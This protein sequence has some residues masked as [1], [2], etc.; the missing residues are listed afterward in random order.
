MQIPFFVIGCLLV[1]VVIAMFPHFMIYY[2]VV[3]ITIIA[4]GAG[5]MVCG[6]LN[7]GLK[8]T[9]VF[10]VVLPTALMAVFYAYVEFIARPFIS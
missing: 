4:I 5:L 3:A 9:V 7:I 1:V 2:F 6:F 8:R 10:A